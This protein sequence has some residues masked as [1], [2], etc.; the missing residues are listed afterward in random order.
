[1]CGSAEV[2]PS[3]EEPHASQFNPTHFVAEELYSLL[4][5]VDSESI[6]D[7]FQIGIH[8]K[9]HDF[10]SHVK[11]AIREGIDPSSSLDELADK[12]AVDDV[13]E[14]MPKSRFS[15]LTNDRD[16]RAVVQ[17]LFTLLHT[18]QLYHQ[19]AVQR[20]RLEW[21]V[22]PVVSLDATNL[23]LTRSVV[24][25][26]DFLGDDDESYEIDPADGGIRLH[27]SVS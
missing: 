4:D 16:Y 25:S 1:M 21:L 26:G 23:E 24:V 14:K 15:E 22:E 6:A 7:D 11:V 9:K 2:R 27:L 18:P 20:K 19:R 13:L 5:A 10:E 17:L 12:T 8:S 3:I